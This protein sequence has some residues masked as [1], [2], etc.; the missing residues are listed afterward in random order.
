VTLA[1]DCREQGGSCECP[2]QPRAW[3]VDVYVRVGVLASCQE[4]AERMAL[5]VV[6]AAPLRG[7]S[8]PGCGRAVPSL[9][10]ASSVRSVGADFPAGNNMPPERGNAGGQENNAMTAHIVAARELAP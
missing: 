3:S 4:E 1:P 6:R 9:A 7:L 2:R 8:V 10:I 5:A